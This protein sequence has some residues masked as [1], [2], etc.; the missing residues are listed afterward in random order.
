[1]MPA[2]ENHSMTT[3]QEWA[4]RL[5]TYVAG[6]E[7]V[8]NLEARLTRVRAARMADKTRFKPHPLG[9]GYLTRDER[10]M[11]VIWAIERRIAAA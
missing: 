11:E 6:R 5:P 1:M 3:S 7:F 10:W 8:T 9:D 2:K 4:E